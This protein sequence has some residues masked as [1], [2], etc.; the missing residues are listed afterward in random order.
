[1]KIGDFFQQVKVEVA[2][3]DWPTK[4]ETIRLTI[5]VVVV[6]MLIAVFLGAF[7]FLFL[8]IIKMIQ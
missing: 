5:I 6:F 1:M 2:K 4:D 7:D 3:V 8:E